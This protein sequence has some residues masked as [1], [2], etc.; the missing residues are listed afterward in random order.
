L[1]SISI[2]ENNMAIEWRDSYRLGDAGI[3]AQHQTMFALVNRLL[4][5]TE[6]PHVTEAVAN[7]FKHTRDHFTHEESRMRETDYP[8][9]HAHVE[10]HNTLLAKLG[11]A[12]ELIDNY[13]LTMANLESFLAVWLI[14]HM[15]T[16]DAPLV[17]HIRRQ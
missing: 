8:G 15:E 9:R 16:L 10:Q 11:H 17:N 2:P 5:A 14:K 3:D 7:L 13:S 1:A 12:S 6:K 4:A